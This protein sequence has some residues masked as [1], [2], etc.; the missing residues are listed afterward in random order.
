MYLLKNSKKRLIDIVLSSE[1]YASLCGFEYPISLLSEEKRSGHIELLSK[2][3]TC[4]NKENIR[5]GL[6]VWHN[7]LYVPTIETKVVDDG[8]HISILNEREL[9]YPV[10]KKTKAWLDGLVYYL[11]KL[12]EQEN[13]EE[14]ERTAVKIYEEKVLKMLME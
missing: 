6:M 13:S 9:P 7:K 10:I 3:E 5:C 4:Y 12:E 1:Y 2:V 8:V 14:L 11:K